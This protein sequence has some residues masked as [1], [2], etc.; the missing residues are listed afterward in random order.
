MSLRILVSFRYRSLAQ[1]F[2]VGIAAFN[3]FLNFRKLRTAS[4]AAS[5][6]Y[7]LLSQN[8]ISLPK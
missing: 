8:H 2:Y 3:E 5:N 6:V 7:M 1:Q 4:V